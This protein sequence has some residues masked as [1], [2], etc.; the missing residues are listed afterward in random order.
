[1]D[2]SRIDIDIYREDV[3]RDPSLAGMGAR[4]LREHYAR[5][6]PAAVL[7]AEGA[8]RQAARRALTSYA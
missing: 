6:N 8:R 1:M 2:P 4:E 7:T 3:A 5:E